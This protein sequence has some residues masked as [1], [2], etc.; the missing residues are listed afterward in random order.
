MDFGGASMSVDQDRKR[1]SQEKMLGSLTRELKTTEM[2]TVYLSQTVDT[3]NYGVFCALVPNSQ[4]DRIISELAWDL[5][6]DDGAPCSVIYHRDG[7]Q[8]VK[9]L[10]FGDD[11]GIEPL[12]IDRAFHGMRDDYKEISEEFRLFHRLYHDKKTDQYLKFDDDGNETVVVIVEEDRVR[13]RVKEIRQFLAIRDMH[14]S[15]QF[16]C[17]EDSSYSLEELGLEEGGDDKWQGLACWGLHYGDFGG[18]GEHRAFSRLLGKRL[19]EPLPKSKSGLWGFA[20]EAKKQHADFIINVDKNGDEEIHTSHPDTLANFFGANPEAPIYLT[21]VTFRKQVLDKYYQQPSKYSVEDSILRCGSLWC[22][23]IDNHHDDKVCVWLGD[24]GRNLS[25]QEQLHWRA[26]NIAPLGGVSETYFKRQIL[27]QFTD[28]ER[29]EHLFATQYRRLQEDSE[30]CL[31]WQLFLP[32]DAG[33]EH[34]TKCI[35]IPA[36]GEQRE[37]DELVLGLTKLL[38]DSLNEKELN[39]LIPENDRP[40]IKG[41][42]LRLEAVLAVCGVEDASSH[43]AFLRKLQNL[44]SSSS[45]HRKGSNYRKIAKDFGVD[46]QSLSAVFGEIMGQALSF[47]DFLAVTVHGRQLKKC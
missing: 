19:V 40:N 29:P 16:D 17:R 31:G 7:E 5:S 18:L 43:I 8:R 6:H 34:Y 12:V 15:I 1:L 3:Y 36:T 24:L 46:E 28:S 20:E 42:I 14:L 47:L 4:V 30:N 37:F 11:G 39:K 23:Q 35:R 44:R 9:Y 26:H 27:A 32:L 38:I 45:A 13:I 33:D 25:Y 21:P 41:S 10:R 2:L 22:L